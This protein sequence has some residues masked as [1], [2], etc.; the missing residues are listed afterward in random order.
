MSGGRLWGIDVIAAIYGLA[1]LLFLWLFFFGTLAGVI[2]A[3]V[4]GPLCATI[5]IG[6]AQRVNWVRIL[7]ITLLLISLA[8]NLILIL[9]LAGAIAGLFPVRPNVDPV[10]SL[11]S[12]PI[13]IALTLVMYFY[14]RRPDVRAAFSFKRNDGAEEPA[15]LLRDKL[16]A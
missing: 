8:G 11:M 4:L 12:R 1:T 2:A 6:I 16:E 13:N 5:A 14:L 7:L 15:T 9:Y 3:A 10:D